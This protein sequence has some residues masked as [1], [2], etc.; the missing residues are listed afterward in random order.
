MIKKRVTSSL[1]AAILMLSFA[2]CGQEPQS[3]SSQEV[4]LVEPVVEAVIGEKAAYRNLYNYKVYSAT[5][6]PTVRE[7]AFTATTELADYGAFWGEEVKKNE[8]LAFGSTESID[9]QIENMEERIAT[10]DENILEAQADLEESLA[11]DKLQEANWESIVK[12]YEAGTNKPAEMVPASSLDPTTTST[13][14]VTNPAYTEYMNTWR[15]FEGKYR[16]IAHSIDM[17]EVAFEQQKQL[18]ELERAY[19]VEQLNEM[20]ASRKKNVIVAKEGGEV[21]ALALGDSAQMSAEQP[22]VAIGNMEEKI[23]R[24]DYISK[25]DMSKADDVYALINGKRYEVEYVPMSNEEYAEITAEGGKAYTTFKFTGDASDVEIGGYGVITL[26]KDKK[27]NVLSVPKSALRKD[28]NGYFVYVM[29][30]GDSVYTSVKIGITDGA[31]TEILSGI[32]E[33]DMIM[34]DTVME[35][36]DE[37]A[38]VG[39]GSYSTT[40]KNNGHMV[41]CESD[42]VSNPVEYGT[43][44][45]GEYL[46]V[47]YQHV[48]KGDV[49]ATIRVKKDAITIQRNKVKLQRMQERLNELIAE[50]NENN[51][52]IIEDR[53]E[54]IAELQE[55][56]KDMESDAVM[57]QIRAP[58]SGMVTNLG[59]YENETILYYESFIAEIADENSC[60]LELENTNQQLNYGNEVTIT[61]T[62]QDGS[63]MTSSGVVAS[64][65]ASGVSSDLQSEYAYILLPEESISD[66]ALSNFNRENYW[67]RNRYQVTA[68]VRRMDNILVVPRNA[69]RDIEGCT[70]V[71][72]KDEQ[73]NVKAISFVA[74][75]Y[76][77]SEYWVIEGLTEGMVLCLK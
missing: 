66:M 72:V 36:S 44:Y 29:K 22:V 46:V 68:T 48:E 71:Y 58:R 59:R 54:Q 6:Y 28:E 70:Y 41:Y 19:L 11:P 18:Y 65:S 42:T 77:A 24:T 55:L 30:G 67:N 39:Y 62:A 10:M 27:E 14:M 56:I 13:E 35:Y 3:V 75:G 9:E 32:S 76:N 63:G 15:M 4:A 50:N 16:I 17:R 74:A 5:I 52:D 61:Y 21:V 8:T 12:V 26:F 20:K 53:Q 73:G 60:Y 40:F 45:F 47:P 7:Y 69:V 43:T 38:T 49:I 31:Y 2:G 51:K 57:T 1:L 37:T 64:V 34:V 33:G 25:S 23:L